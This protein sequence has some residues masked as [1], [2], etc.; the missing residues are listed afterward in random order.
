MHEQT[1]DTIR[2][3]WKR[4]AFAYLRFKLGLTTFPALHALQLMAVGKKENFYTQLKRVKEKERANWVK[5]RREEKS[6]PFDAL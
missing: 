6:L 1:R 2:Y 5:E 4:N 3:A